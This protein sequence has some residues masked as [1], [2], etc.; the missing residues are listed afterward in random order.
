MIFQETETIE[1]KRVLNDSLPKE[2]NRCIFEQF[3]W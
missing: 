1:L 3:R 2:I